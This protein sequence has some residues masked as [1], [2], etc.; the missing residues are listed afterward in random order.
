MRKVSRGTDF[1]G[2]LRYNAKNRLIGGNMTSSEGNYQ[3]VIKVRRNTTFDKEQSAANKIVVA[4]N[5]AF[6]DPKVSG[7]RRPFRMAGFWNKKPER[8]D[9]ITQIDWGL[10]SP[11]AICE[12]STVIERP[13]FA[14]VRQ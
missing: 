6:G 1:R 10:S 11:E 13:R 2:V 3:A 4:I 5:K 9:E 8:D 12:L 14:H 7:V